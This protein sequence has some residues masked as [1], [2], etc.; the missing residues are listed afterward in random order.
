M[1]QRTISDGDARIV[2]DERESPLLLITWFGEPNEA[3]ITEYF[4]WMVAMVERFHAS[5]GKYVLI[6]DASSAKR[7]RPSVR[8]QIAERTDA[9]PPYTA[10]INIGN[11]VVIDNP[12]IRGAL[13]AM[14][15]MSRSEWTNKTVGSC[16]EAIRLGLED[17]DRHG[18]ARPRGLDPLAYQ[19][20]A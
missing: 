9:L 16:T 7:P 10:D 6:T 13:T 15:W 1:S 19:R 4:D 3:M 17:L 11:Y 18:I 12:L 14:Q 8:Q 2:V 5:G 20:P